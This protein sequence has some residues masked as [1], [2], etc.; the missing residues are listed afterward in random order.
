MVRTRPLPLD[1]LCLGLGNL[2][3]SQPS[4]NP[5]VAWQLSIERVLQMNDHLIRSLVSI[6]NGYRSAQTMCLH[7]SNANDGSSRRVEGKQSVSF[8]KG[9][10]ACVQIQTHFGSSIGGKALGHVCAGIKG[11]ANCH[12][13]A[14]NFEYRQTRWMNRCL[15]MFSTANHTKSKHISYNLRHSNQF[16]PYIYANFTTS[17]NARSFH[18]QS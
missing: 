17:E 3:V 15:T 6:S 11:S 8:L 12:R 10:F 4:C 1:F 14:L 5:R 7:L 13:I 9:S 2:A 18:P 16:D